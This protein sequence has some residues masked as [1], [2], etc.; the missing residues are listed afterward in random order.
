MFFFPSGDCR[1]TSLLHGDLRATDPN[2]N[3]RPEKK[4]RATPRSAAALLWCCPVGKVVSWSLAIDVYRWGTASQLCG[5]PTCALLVGSVV[6][7]KP[8]DLQSRQGVLSTCACLLGVILTVSRLFKNWVFLWLRWWRCYGDGLCFYKGGI[9]VSTVLDTMFIY[10][11]KIPFWWSD[12][13]DSRFGSIVWV[14]VETRKIEI[15]LVKVL[16]GPQGV[17]K[18]IINHLDVSEIV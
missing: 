5:F 18:Q 12:P 14:D 10:T 6:V 3:D 1:A 9:V 7:W 16:G 13:I 4:I 2:P 17:Q 11:W 15:A 8:Q